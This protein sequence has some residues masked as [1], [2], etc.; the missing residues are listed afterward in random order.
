[1]FQMLSC[2]NLKPGVA[3]AAF[4]QSVADFTSHLEE[5]DPIQSAGPIGRRQSDTI[6]DTDSERKHEFFFVLSFRDRGQCDRAVEH[7][8]SLEEPADR[9]HKDVYSQI[10]DQVFIC[11]EDI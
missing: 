7:I 3:L 11:W 1:M 8:V 10:T 4:R 6:M 9:T 2:F 5:I